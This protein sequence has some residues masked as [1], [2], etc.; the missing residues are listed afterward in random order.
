M[1]GEERD[2]GHARVEGAPPLHRVAALCAATDATPGPHGDAQVMH[3]R[4]TA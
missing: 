4:Y 2:G 3:T 1:E